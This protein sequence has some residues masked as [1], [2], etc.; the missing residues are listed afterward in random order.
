MIGYFVRIDYKEE[1]VALIKGLAEDSDF[2]KVLFVYHTG[3]GQENP[4]WHG[5]IGT[6][7]KDSTMRKRMKRIFTLGKGNGHMSIKPWETDGAVSYMFHENGAPITVCKGFDD[8]EIV[9]ARVAN[10][11]IQ[12]E[13][14]KA[15]DKASWK[16][17]EQAYEKLVARKKEYYS[18][19]EIGMTIVELALTGDKYVPN[20]WL[21]RAMVT[22]LQYKLAKTEVDQELVI[23]SIVIKALR[24]EN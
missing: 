14:K 23:K 4:H 6:S 22:K 5:C 8:S 20:D 1:Y 17:E 7:L 11:K 16:L 10:D 2:N 24:L 12:E 18:E 21:L 15:K 9:K 19:M 3:E 13:V